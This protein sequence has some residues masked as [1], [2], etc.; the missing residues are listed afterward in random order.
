MIRK[1]GNGWN[2]KPYKNNLLL[3]FKEEWVETA[4]VRSKQGFL[5]CEDIKAKGS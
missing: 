3:Q 2:L 5:V 1:K 4:E